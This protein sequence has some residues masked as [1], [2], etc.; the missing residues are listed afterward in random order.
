MLPHGTN[1]KPSATSLLSSG[2]FTPLTR[3]HQPVAK[4]SFFADNKLHLPAYAG[5]MERMA[6]TGERLQERFDGID[7][8][9][10][11]IDRRFDEVD[12]RFDDVDRRFGEVD[13]R[14]DRLETRYSSFVGSFTLRSTVFG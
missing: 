6:W 7:R 5:I 13:R 2:I 10:D 1:P 3:S 12:R 14:F 8:R 11:G 9:F 4:R